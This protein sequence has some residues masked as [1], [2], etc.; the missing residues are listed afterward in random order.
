MFEEAIDVGIL[1]AV[2]D[3]PEAML[4]DPKDSAEHRHFVTAFQGQT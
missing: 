3:C 4:P 2:L 1:F